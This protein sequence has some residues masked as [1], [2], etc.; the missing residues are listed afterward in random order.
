MAKK[1]LPSVWPRQA[2]K[3]GAPAPAVF[4]Q[5]LIN[6]SGDTRALR[7]HRE[8]SHRRELAASVAKALRRSDEF[9][10]E[11]SGMWGMIAK[12]TLV[13][14]RRDEMIEILKESAGA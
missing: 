9:K 13:P 4:V 3:T 5:K 7:R 6:R 2:D 1:W 14:G 8:R 10:E 12:I 11:A